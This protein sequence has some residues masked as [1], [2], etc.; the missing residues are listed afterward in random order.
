MRLRRRTI[1][2]VPQQD[3]AENRSR[4]KAELAA[5]LVIRKDDAGT[6]DIG[7]HQIDGELNPVEAQIER[8]SQRLDQ[9]GLP[10]AGNT[11]DQNV[12]TRKKSGEELLDRKLWP[13]T[14][15][16]TSA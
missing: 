10:R 5:S 11:F 16:R 6:R 12:T 4:L 13:M 3:M 14:A 15:L 9:R 7:G 8:Q 2:L 1:D